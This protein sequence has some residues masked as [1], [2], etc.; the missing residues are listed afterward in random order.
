MYTPPDTI[1]SH[2]DELWNARREAAH[3][4]VIPTNRFSLKSE[5]SREPEYDGYS[6]RDRH[7]LTS[8]ATHIKEDGSADDVSL[9]SSR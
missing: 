7:H 6:R 5:S 9:G 3:G 1:L 2:R 4:D 8:D